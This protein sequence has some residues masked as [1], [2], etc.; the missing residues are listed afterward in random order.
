MQPRCHGKQG[1]VALTPS[2]HPIWEAHARPL[3]IPATWKYC[4]KCQRSRRIKLVEDIKGLQFCKRNNRV[5]R[6]RQHSRRASFGRGGRDATAYRH[7]QTQATQIK[8]TT[9]ENTIIHIF[10]IQWLTHTTGISLKTPNQVASQ[11]P[12]GSSSR[13]NRCESEGERVRQA[14]TCHHRRRP[15][16]VSSAHIPRQN[17]R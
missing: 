6:K 5:G 13:K 11:P 10:T 15:A 8:L 12:S 3:P 2:H 17:Q 14:G 1:R 4:G 7:L 16:F 9:R